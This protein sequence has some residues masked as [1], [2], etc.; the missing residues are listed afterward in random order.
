[1]SAPLHAI[2]SLRQVIAHKDSLLAVFI[3]HPETLVVRD[4]MPV[5]L[6]SAAS[7]SS[8]VG[9]WALLASAFFG[10]SFAFL[11]ARIG[12]WLTARLA[13][14]KVHRNALVRLERLT[15]D[16]L[17]AIITNKRLASDS[18][19]A[20][21]SA[22]LYWKFP[23]TFEI[24][25]SYAVDVFD[26][27]MSN[28]IVGMT[29][30]LGRYNNDVEDLR[31]AHAD[32]QH[33]HLGRTLPA[34]EWKEASSRMAP[35]WGQFVGILD[36]MDGDI[37]NILVRAV[38]LVNQYDS[39]RARWLRVIGIVRSWPLDAKQVERARKRFDADR[40]RLLAESARERAALRAASGAGPTA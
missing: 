8:P 34:E 39:R 26:V 4:S 38:L 32:L 25:R 23:H 28:L 11:F 14:G 31:R 2:D 40:A 12:E 20:T 29:T 13:R 36:K 6:P 10:G 35:H 24:D 27:E 19:A 15:T 5:T 7:V 22:H 9:P 37:R 30:D 17:N 18:E 33:A 3:A 16:Y 21:R 1:M